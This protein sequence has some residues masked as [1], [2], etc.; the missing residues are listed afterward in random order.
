VADGGGS[1]IWSERTIAVDGVDLHCA[2]AGVGPAVVVVDGTDEHAGRALE[3]LAEQFHVVALR[4]AEIDACSVQGL[5]DAFGLD[6]FNLVGMSTGADAA[7]RWAIDGHAGLDAVVLSAPTAI[8]SNGASSSVDVAAVAVPTLVLF[9]TDDEIVDPASGRAYQA[10]MPNCFYQLVYAAGH[11]IGADRP[12]AFASVV[13]DFLSWREQF[14][15]RH[16]STVINP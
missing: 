8:V 1:P 3:L 4:S 2:E 14:V 12:E 10:A 16:E 5:A 6:H 11:D 9:G 15:F 13:G 7:L